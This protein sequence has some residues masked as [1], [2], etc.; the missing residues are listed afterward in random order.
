MATY[1]VT[2]LAPTS[3][4]SF[5]KKNTHKRKQLQLRNENPDNISF[6]DSLT[7]LV[8]KGI[9][10]IEDL[11]KTYHCSVTFNG[12]SVLNSEIATNKINN[13]RNEIEYDHIVYPSDCVSLPI[14]KARQ[15][16]KAQL[17]EKNLKKLDYY[18]RYIYLPKLSKDQ[19]F[20][21]DYYSDTDT[22]SSVDSS[23][24]D[25]KEMNAEENYYLDDNL[26]E[27][28]EVDSTDSEI[29]NILDQ[30]LQRFNLNDNDDISYSNSSDESYRKMKN[31]V[32]EFEF[33]NNHA[34]KVYFKLNDIDKT[35]ILSNL[36]NLA[37]FNA[38]IPKEISKEKIVQMF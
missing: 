5:R 33:C 36:A 29:E 37:K 30:R 22:S 35:H 2:H 17:T 38:S 34:A 32:K 13:K 21:N 23:R 4:A 19:N 18:H 7:N 14:R 6:K 1:I 24:N 11:T 28:D 10:T 20:I 16:E 25:L 12:N 31:N 3:Y 9:N 15:Q 26:N 27:F 8:P